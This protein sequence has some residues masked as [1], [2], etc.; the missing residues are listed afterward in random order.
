MVGNSVA[1]G[2]NASCLVSVAM[3]TVP[4]GEGLAQP[5]QVQ[6]FLLIG[7]GFRFPEAPPDPVVGTGVDARLQWTLAAQVTHVQKW[8]TDVGS[9]SFLIPDLEFLPDCV[10]LTQWAFVSPSDPDVLFY[11]DVTGARIRPASVQAGASLSQATA[12]TAAPTTLPAKRAAFRQAF[13]GDSRFAWR[14][15][16][17]PAAL[18]T[19]RQP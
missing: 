4:Q 16:D 12:Q 19:S 2:A 10:L 6:A 17:V 7:L 11:S 3:P 1:I 13:E 5:S 9:A 8:H 18:R 14:A 15:A